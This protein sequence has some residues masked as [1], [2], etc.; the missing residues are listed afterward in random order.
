MEWDVHAWKCDSKSTLGSVLVRKVVERYFL[1]LGG[2][3]P[4]MSPYVVMRRMI[5]ITIT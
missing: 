1:R 4:T 3:A 5:M 2:E